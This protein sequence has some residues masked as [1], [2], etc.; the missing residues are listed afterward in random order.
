MSI[1]FEIADVIPAPPDVVYAAWL[2]SGEHT[3]MTGGRAVVSAKVGESFEAW[4]GYIQG[5]NL[6]LVPGKRILQHWR[7]SEF[8]ESDGDSLL[9]VLLDPEGDGTRVTIRHSDLAEHGMQYRQGWV[10]AYFSPMK[11]Y[12]GKKSKTN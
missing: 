1:E 3:Q 8:D 11:Q 7:T 12:F 10:D 4:D 5:T 6:E 9:E 2:D